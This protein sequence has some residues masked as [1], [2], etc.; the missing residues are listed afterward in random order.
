MGQL[1]GEKDTFLRR[2][3]MRTVRNVAFCVLLVFGFATSKAT[4]H[5][6]SCDSEYLWQDYCNKYYKINC[7][8]S[9]CASEMWDSAWTICDNQGRLL[10]E[11]VCNDI[12]GWATFACNN[13]CVG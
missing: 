11:Y 13:W 10:V 3:V 7:G 1:P 2:L 9:T 4:P 8:P 12:D 5:A 6:M